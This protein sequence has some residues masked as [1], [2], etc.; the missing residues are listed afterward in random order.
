MKNFDILNNSWVVIDPIRESEM[1]NIILTVLREAGV[2][3][4][5]IMIDHPEAPN[6][7]Y[8]NCGLGEHVM[9][10][11]GLGGPRQE[12][13]VRITLKDLML[14]AE[15]LINNKNTNNENTDIL[16]ET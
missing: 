6:F 15:E 13:Y 4:P 12:N 8:I 14:S 7:P 9:A 16:T 11:A 10:S 1:R 2:S 5:Q 3:V